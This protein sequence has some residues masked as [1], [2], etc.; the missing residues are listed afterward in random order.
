[1]AEGRSSGFFTRHRDIKSEKSTLNFC[2][3]FRVG[4][5][6]VGIIKMA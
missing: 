3:S 5:G 2:G 4:G 1:M 6:L